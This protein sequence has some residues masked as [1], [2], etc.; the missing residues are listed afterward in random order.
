MLTPPRQIGNIVCA[1]DEVDYTQL[2]M[3]AGAVPC[4]RQLVAHSTREVQKEACWTL[5]NIAAGTVEQ[6][7]TV[8]DSGERWY[9]VP[10]LGLWCL[11]YTAGVSSG[12]ALLWTRCRLLSAT[13]L[14]ASHRRP[15][16]QRRRCC[17]CGHAA[18][19]VS[20][21]CDCLCCHCRRRCH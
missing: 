4:L 1:E 6:I 2:I 19:A 8:L 12:D 21:P 10:A 16:P 15:C 13:F 18:L 7:Q 5:S 9:C 3:D 17:D 11:A 20:I 14:Q